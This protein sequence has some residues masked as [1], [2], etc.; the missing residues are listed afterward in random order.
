MVDCWLQQSF[1]LQ[2]L[3]Q[4][5]QLSLKGAFVSHIPF[6]QQGLQSLSQVIQFS[7]IA[8]LHMP[9]PHLGVDVVT[10]D[11]TERFVV[12]VRLHDRRVTVQFPGNGFCSVRVVLCVE[13]DENTCI[14]QVVDHVTSV[15][16]AV[17]S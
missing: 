4:V 1:V 16:A 17:D 3:K 11:S 13:T 8:L 5:A 10:Q 12:Q 9:S 2:S 6:P 15:R 14:G 7:P